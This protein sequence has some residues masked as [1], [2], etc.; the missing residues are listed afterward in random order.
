MQNGMDTQPARTVARVT[1]VLLRGGERLEGDP[2]CWAEVEKERKGTFHVNPIRFRC[3]GTFSLNAAFDRFD[4]LPV[5]EAPKEIQ[6][7]LN[8]RRG[9]QRRR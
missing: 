7:F 1:S 3:D 8:R 6:T 2:L 4:I 9:Q 5:D